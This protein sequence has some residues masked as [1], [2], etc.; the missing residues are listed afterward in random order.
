MLASLRV[1]PSL[2][3]TPLARILIP[4]KVWISPVNKNYVG[5]RTAYGDPYHG[6]WVTDVSQLND[7]FGTADDLKALSAE[8]HKRG[9]CV[10]SRRSRNQITEQSNSTTMFKAF[11]R[12]GLLTRGSV[13]PRTSYA[14]AGHL[15]F[16]GSSQGRWYPCHKVSLDHYLGNKSPYRKLSF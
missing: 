14:I 9:M 4:H 13:G 16:P 7:R 3:Q 11:Q 8:L 15:D 6:Y 12:N 1:R 2:S 10:C 5:P